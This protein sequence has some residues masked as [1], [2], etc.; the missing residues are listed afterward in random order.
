GRGRADLPLPDAARPGRRD[1]PDDDPGVGRRPGGLPA[2]ADA[3]GL[4][5]GGRGSGGGGG[6][7]GGGGGSG[8]GRRGGALPAA[9]P[10]PGG[11]VVQPG[12]QLLR[13]AGGAGRAGGRRGAGPRRRGG[14]DAA[15][16]LQRGLA[17]GADGGGGRLGVLA[18]RRR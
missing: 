6:R 13:P 15:R 4:G 7:G 12:H 18:G 14:G 9:R 1:R 3:F 10:G 16:R 2:A 11:G 17:R 8:A 5:G